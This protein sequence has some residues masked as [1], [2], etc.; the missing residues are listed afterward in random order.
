[1][2]A[3]AQKETQKKQ[4]QAQCS[5]NFGW[6]GPTEQQQ[7]ARQSRTKAQDSD[8][9]RTYQAR[10]QIFLLDTPKHSDTRTHS[11]P[12]GHACNA[13]LETVEAAAAAAARAP[14]TSSR[15]ATALPADT[16][17]L[18]LTLVGVPVTAAILLPVHL[19]CFRD[20]RWP[21]SA[22]A[23]AAAITV[24][25]GDSS[26]SP[27]PQQRPLCLSTDKR[28]TTKRPARPPVRLSD[29]HR[30]PASTPGTVRHAQPSP[31]Q[32]GTAPRAPRPTQLCDPRLTSHPAL[33]SYSTTPHSEF[34][35]LFGKTN[36]RR[37]KEKT[38]GGRRNTTARKGGSKR[39]RR[40]RREFPKERAVEKAAESE[41]YAREHI[42][43]C[44][45]RQL[46]GRNQQSWGR[47]HGQSGGPAAQE[48]ENTADRHH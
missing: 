45:S 3:G 40:S 44:G 41:S 21:L 13:T 47:P 30:P 34:R 46:T 29:E 39:R 14:A 38:K 7:Q 17:L 37:K 18:P 24:A 2:L 9:N 16:A 10:T 11:C 22:A 25:V 36:K 31:A 33:R 48:E 26:S 12:P 32:A 43:G 15:P 35:W 28:Q 20:R 8:S 6:I 19:S 1:M 23:S 27:I 42:S 5:H 4:A